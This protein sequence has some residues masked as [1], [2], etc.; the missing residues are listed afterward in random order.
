MIKCKLTLTDW[1]T[2]KEIVKAIMPKDPRVAAEI[3]SRNNPACSVLLEYEKNNKLNVVTLPPYNMVIDQLLVEECE[4][5]L[6]KFTNK[7]Y[8]KIS[9]KRLKEIEKELLKEIADEFGEEEEP[10]DEKMIID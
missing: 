1:F 2:K 10:V 9:K 8:G 6:N 3:H 7:W 4:L 5:S